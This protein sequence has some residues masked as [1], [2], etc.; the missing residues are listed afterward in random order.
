ME[1]HALTFRVL[2]GS[3]DRV[4]RVLAAY[5]RPETEIGNGCRLLSTTVFLWDNR[6]V[7]V[8]DVEG[9]LAAVAGHLAS[10]PAIR[11]TEEELNPFLVLPRDFSDPESVG[12]F[13]R[14]ALMTRVVHH[15]V[16]RDS[17]EQDGGRTRVA[18]RYP[19]R[20]G[21]G[22]AAARLFAWGQSLPLGTALGTALVDTT[23][24]RKGDLVIRVLDVEGDPD[25]ALDRLGPVVLGGPTAPALTE[26]LEPGWNLGTAAGRARF[27]AEQRMTV[28]THREAGDVTGGPGPGT[29]SAE[30]SPN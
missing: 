2:R 29:G 12:R 19:V 13:F 5:P 28:V 9:P 21:R 6:V 20:P 14:R 16:R 11:R 1:R 4:R 3:E 22:E 18:L 10:D 26:L 15:R 23:V 24:F 7:R 17:P 8:I 30:L 25:E 27:L